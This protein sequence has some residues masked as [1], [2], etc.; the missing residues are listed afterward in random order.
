MQTTTVNVIAM[1]GSLVC[2]WGEET[3]RV[4][5]CKGAEMPEVGAKIEVHFTHTKAS[6]CPKYATLRAPKPAEEPEEEDTK[7][8]EQ[9]KACGGA[10]LSAGE[11]VFV[12]GSRDPTEVHKV[13][14]DRAG[15]SIY[16]SCPAW[17]YQRIAP[18]LRTCKHC[19]AVRCCKKM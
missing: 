2:A 3:L 4:R 6:G 13:T 15:A 19:E 11:F 16:C 14:M 5:V 9:W 17:K 8:M 10:K 7:T 12:R 18:I 1:D